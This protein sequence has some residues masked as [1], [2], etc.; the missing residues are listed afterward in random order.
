MSISER[1]CVYYNVDWDFGKELKR[2]A[3][4]RTKEVLALIVYPEVFA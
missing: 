4:T 3:V 2:L 1:V